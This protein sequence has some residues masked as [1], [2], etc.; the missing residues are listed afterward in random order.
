MYV[1]RISSYG[2][3]F[4]EF[5]AIYFLSRHGT[6]IVENRT[7]GS[8]SLFSQASSNRIQCDTLR[9]IV[10]DHDIPFQAYIFVTTGT[11]VIDGN[12]LFTCII[13]VLSFSRTLDDE[14]FSCVTVRGV[15]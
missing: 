7:L 5:V 2:T 15:R 12:S 10:T 8:H 4:R 1:L 3:S 9:I 6:D 14:L 13:A 11:S